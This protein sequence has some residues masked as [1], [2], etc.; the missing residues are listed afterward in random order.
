MTP[1]RKELEYEFAT[2][3]GVEHFTFIEIYLRGKFYSGSEIESIADFY[4]KYERWL[5]VNNICKSDSKGM[6]DYH[7]KRLYNETIPH[8]DAMYILYGPYVPHTYLI[9]EEV[10]S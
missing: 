8:W 1:R 4:G 10:N 5:D 2:L 9:D 3:R 7:S 6:R